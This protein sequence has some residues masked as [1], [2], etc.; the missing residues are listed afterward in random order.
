MR[1]MLRRLTPL[2]EVRALITADVKPVAAGERAVAAAAGCV[3]AEDAVAPARPE[4]AIALQ[5]GWAL[6]ADETQGASAYAPAFL[7][8]VPPQIDAGQP[9]L[10]GCDCVAGF[11]DVRVSGAQAEALASFAPGGGV[12]GA[13]GDHDGRAP[14]MRAGERMSAAQAAALAAL[15]IATVRVRAPRVLIAP[16]RADAFLA[17]A[18]DF[19]KQD[20]QSHGDEIETMIGLDAALTS[21]TADLIVVIGGTGSGSN[22]T[23]VTALAQAGKIAVHGIALS[24]GET[25]GFGFVAHRP[26]LLLPGR[27]DGAIAGGLMLGR[28]LCDR[29]SGAREPTE[30]GEILTLARKITSTVG[31]TELVPVRRAEGRAEPLAGRTWPLSAI[32][33]ADGYVVIPPDSEGSSAGSAVQVWPLL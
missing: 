8:S 18:A 17:P 24:P 22:D 31:L 19:M 20:L 15:G 27:V 23:S 1:Q 28:F 9:M 29:L 16:V 12:L 4:N 6:R 14:V 32:A 2:A 33:R 10:E 3:L 30:R 7:S 26:V 11:D 21:T 25:S 5:D 13:G